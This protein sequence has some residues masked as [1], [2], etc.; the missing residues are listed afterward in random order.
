[1]NDRRGLP[2]AI[3]FPS[4]YL[5]GGLEPDCAL[6]MEVKKDSHS[7]HLFVRDPDPKEELWE[8]PRTKAGG[9]AER[10]FGVERCRSICELPGFLKGYEGSA[11]GNFVL[12]YE[13]LSPKNDKIHK[14][15]MN[16]IQN[17]SSNHG[18]QTP[19]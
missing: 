18:I 4:R 15:M 9:E 11:R 17:I 10:F 6:V 3:C 14:V 5:T 19:K 2:T 1:M 12:W 13:Y 7:S 8:G 16:F